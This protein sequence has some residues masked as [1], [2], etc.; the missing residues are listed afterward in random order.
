MQNKANKSLEEVEKSL[1]KLTSSISKTVTFSIV[2]KADSLFNKYKD[3]AINKIKDSIKN[4][5]TALKNSIDEAFGKF[6]NSE[7]GKITAGD[8]QHP[9]WLQIVIILGCSCLLVCI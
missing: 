5:Q 3:E 7:T 1:L 2:K 9:Y 8:R 6:G 4:G